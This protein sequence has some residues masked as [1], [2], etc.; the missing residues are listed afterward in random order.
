[1]QCVGRVLRCAGEMS[2]LSLVSA[3]R[4]HHVD[5]PVLAEIRAKLSAARQ[6]THRPTVSYRAGQQP[7]WARSEHQRHHTVEATGAA[8]EAQDER[9]AAQRSTRVV[10]R[11]E[12]V[13]ATRE[14]SRASQTP[15]PSPLPPTPPRAAQAPV[16]LRPHSTLAVPEPEHESDDEHDEHVRRSRGD[17]LSADGSHARADDARA[18]DSRVRLVDGENGAAQP[19]SDHEAEAEAEAQ[20]SEAD[21]D[22]DDGDEDDVASA[23]SLDSLSSSSHSLHR[24]LT[25]KPLFQPR[26][27][28]ATLDERDDT[29]ATDWQRQQVDEQQRDRRRQHTRQQLRADMDRAA[30]RAKLRQLAADYGVKHNQ[31]AHMPDDST[32]S[33][34]DD[35]ERDA[36][37]LRELLR[38]SRD[39]EALQRRRRQEVNEQE[40]DDEGQREASRL[41]PINTDNSVDRE[42]WQ[43]EQASFGSEA[44]SVAGQQRSS[45][46]F[47][48]RYYHVG[49]FFADER[50]TDS[51]FQRDFNAATG[52]DRTVDKQTLPAVMQVKKFGLKGRTKYTHLR[53]QDTSQPIVTQ[54]QNRN[55]DSEHNIRRAAEVGVRGYTGRGAVS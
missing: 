19:T 45:M 18:A 42:N 24:P 52:E 17:R 30:E 7:D 46:R 31:L 34:D 1:M 11:A 35:S 43:G 29:D 37:K 5:D 14:G 39:K 28:R 15:L 13:V 54:R 9:S 20:Q 25:S 44:D 32:D 16:R 33:E 48:Q 27:A 6:A 23:A 47:L 26:A 41:R 36:W 10:R 21:D 50:P 22:D 55:L 38:L 40:E 2:A 4:S 3:G 51:A 12:V 53:D 49:A 8:S